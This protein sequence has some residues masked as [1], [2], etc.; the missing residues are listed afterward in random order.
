MDVFRL[1]ITAIIAGLVLYF[2][3]SLMAP[4]LKPQTN[5]SKAT[6]NILLDAQA[7]L[8]QS[9]SISLSINADQSLYARNFDTPTR[10]VSFACAG[11][12]CCP[13]LEKCPSAYGSTPERMLTFQNADT[14]LT[15]RCE[16]SE[17]GIHACVVYVGKEPAQVMWSTVSAPSGTLTTKNE[18]TFSGMIRNTGELTSNTLN[19]RVEIW[20]TTI[21][22]GK[23]VET[24]V[25]QNGQTLEGIESG[26][27]QNVSIPITISTPGE[28]R[29]VMSVEGL[30][31]GKDTREFS[32]V[33][34]GDLIS[35]CAPD[36]TKAFVKTYD[37]FDDVCKEKRFCMNCDFAF[38]CRQAW[39]REAPV[40][41][42]YFYD[43][44]HGE[45]GFTYLI[46]PAENGTC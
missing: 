15:A 10:T 27:T 43:P 28:Y 8:G 39:Q 32:V 3:S 16:L 22:S 20:G 45:T 36:F 42:P 21:V 19:M 24:I 29:A 34:V 12:E 18:I 1:L 35:L 6:E 30:D 13:Y 11:S 40:E 2:L 23:D 4:I 41:L 46:S 31:A 37:G 7:D 5:L 17:A 9:T 44:T 33:M 25:V 38:S 14:S 26:K